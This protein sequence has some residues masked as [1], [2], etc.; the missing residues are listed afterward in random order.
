MM[1]SIIKIIKK[2]IKIVIIILFIYTFTINI[3][4]L[5]KIYNSIL[6]IDTYVL[7]FIL[8][9]IILLT[10]LPLLLGYFKEYSFVKEYIFYT[11]FL[12]I[13]WIIFKTQILILREVIAVTN[14]P[15]KLLWEFVDGNIHSKTLEYN[16]VFFE[17]NWCLQFEIFI[18]KLNVTISD[19]S[20]QQILVRVMKVWVFDFIVILKEN[21]YWYTT[22]DV[23]SHFELS[24]EILNKCLETENCLD[25]YNILRIEFKRLSTEYCELNYINVS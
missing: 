10:I 15:F 11:F 3:Y 16:L 13:L 18:F 9:L 8:A 22:F 5:G 20:F 25:I 12:I 4:A 7:L 14:A 21:N 17:G 23:L 2:I 19:R 6:I 1:S 24:D